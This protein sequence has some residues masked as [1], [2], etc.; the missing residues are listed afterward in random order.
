MASYTLAANIEKMKIEDINDATFDYIFSETEKDTENELV[1]EM[2]DEFNYWYPLDMRVSA[3]ELLQNHFIFFL[4]NH[5]AIFDEKNWPRSIGI[6]GWL[7]VNGEKLSKSKGATLTIKKGLEDY[8]ADELR[9]IAAAGNGMDDVEWDP[10]TINTFEPRFEF[11]AELMELKK[12]FE[13]GPN[14]FDAYLNSRLIYLTEQTKREMENF[15]Y[16]AA[17]SHSFFELYNEIKAYMELG[18]NDEK[19]VRQAVMAFIKLNHP[20]FPH[21]TSEIYSRLNTDGSRI[22]PSWEDYPSG[23]RNEVLENEVAILRN[24]IDDIKNVLRLIKRAPKKITL[25]IAGEK[26]FELYN[27]V[28]AEARRTKNTNEIRKTLRTSDKLL[29]KLLKNVNRL[30]EKELNGNLELKVLEEGKNYLEKAFGC[31]VEV[32][33]NTENERAVPGKP[34]INI[35]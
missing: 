27:K 25:E 17:M 26:K 12:T 3:K 7:T 11:V 4:M 13:S 8:G 1:K 21:I 20:F 19:T 14:S 10:D 30:P 6:N 2:K 15:R 16:G 9:M 33:R 24:T 18:G 29:D 5:A 23:I 35:I 34:A 31:K 32:S 28:V 22:Q